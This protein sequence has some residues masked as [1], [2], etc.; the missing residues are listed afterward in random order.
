MDVSIIKFY[1]ESFDSG[2]YGW[3]KMKNRIF[4]ILFIKVDIIVFRKILFIINGFKN[5]VWF[6]FL[7]NIKW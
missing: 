4:D 3:M 1:L 6:F 7:E 5:N 2:N